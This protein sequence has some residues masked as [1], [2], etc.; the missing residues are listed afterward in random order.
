[1]GNKEVGMEAADA[2]KMEWRGTGTGALNAGFE[3]AGVKEVDW[4][5]SWKKQEGVE[6]IVPLEQTEEGAG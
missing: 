4:E 6:V 2:E 1:M 5:S 3:N